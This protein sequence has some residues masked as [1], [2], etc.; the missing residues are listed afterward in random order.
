LHDGRTSIAHFDRHGT[1][2]ETNE[3]M[4]MNTVN[5]KK[6]RRRPWLPDWLR[7]EWVWEGL[8]VVLIAPAIATSILSLGSG[9]TV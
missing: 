8:L 3:E 1:N 7:E 4:N 5:S 2:D 9:V 6:D